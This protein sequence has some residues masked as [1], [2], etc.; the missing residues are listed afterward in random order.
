MMPM[1]KKDAAEDDDAVLETGRIDDPDISAE[2]N[3]TQSMIENDK[4]SSNP[5]N[6]MAAARKVPEEEKAN[7]AGG[8]DSGGEESLNISETNESISEMKKDI[9]M[10][11][12]NEKF[13]N[14]QRGT[15]S[16][17]FSMR[18]DLRDPYKI[19]NRMVLEFN[20]VGSQIYQLW[21]K[22]IEII[23]INPKFV[24]ELLHLMYEER[25]KERWGEN[26]F[27]TVIETK[28]FAFPDEE[29]VGEIHK[30]IAKK[31]RNN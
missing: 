18:V 4:P 25:M 20:F 27:R 9:P 30:Q 3:V 6:E 15:D 24:C 16:V 12:N 1:K 29:N 17:P 26:I 19:A 11:K 21:Y 14:Q 13:L 8:E 31:R 28:D 7:K 23:T 2:G 10:L 5:A 22:L